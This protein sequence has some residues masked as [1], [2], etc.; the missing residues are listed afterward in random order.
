MSI[1][2]RPRS[3]RALIIILTVILNLSCQDESKKSSSSNQKNMDEKLIIITPHPKRVVTEFENS[4]IDYYKKK[5]NKTISLEFL[6]LGGT[7]DDLKFIKSEFSKNK[8]GINVDIFWGGGV[9][10]YLAL[11]ELSLLLKYIPP[12]EILSKIPADVSGIPLYDS[13]HY[14]Y[15]AALASFGFIC[16]KVL[17]DLKKLKPPKDWE[18]LGSPK[19]LGVIG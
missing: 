17:L 15:G 11:K 14:W 8:E 19:Y 1:Q 10:P 9:A 18:D 16:N 5:F 2:L 6:D 4:F 3:F 7:S 13:E 12:P